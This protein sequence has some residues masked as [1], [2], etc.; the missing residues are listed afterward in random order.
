MQFGGID[1]II[2]KQQVK[3]SS[4]FIGSTEKPR[5]NDS[6]LLLCAVFVAFIALLTA[7]YLFVQIL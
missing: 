6:G 1:L 3:G 4:P 5:I 2:R 7:E